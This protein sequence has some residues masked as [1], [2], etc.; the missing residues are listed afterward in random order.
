MIFVDLKDKQRT[1]LNVLP[2]RVY[3][4]FKEEPA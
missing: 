4:T 2:V 1:L 3:S